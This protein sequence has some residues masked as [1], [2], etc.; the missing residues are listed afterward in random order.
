VAIAAQDSRA[1]A[2]HGS[3]AI[4][5]AGAVAPHAGA[6]TEHVSARYR[7]VVVGVSTAVNA[8]AW[9]VRATFALFFVAML[10]EFDWGRGQTALGYSLS[11]LG[12]VVFAP[13]AGWL[14][15]RWG[16]RTVVTAGGLTLGLA[17]VLTG[18]T[19]SLAQYYL[20]FGLLGAAGLACMLV[21][22]TTVVTRWF[23]RSRGVA[24]G[25]LSAGNSAGA[26]AFYPVNAWLIA[27]LG[28]RGALVACGG[29]VAC[30]TVALALIYRN[31][32]LAGQAGGRDDPASAARRLPRPGQTWT[33][34]RASRN[35]R[36][37]AAFGMT[38]FGVVG[39]Q[40]V[41]THQVAHAVDRGFDQT[42]VVWLFAFGAGCMMAGNLLGGWL[43]DQLGRGWVFTLGSVVAIGGIGCLAAIRGPHDVRLLL[44]YTVSAFGFGMRIPQ[45]STIPAD[46]FSGPHL[47]AILG[48]VQAG[49]G[50]GG[51]IGPFLGGWLFDVTGS[52][53]LAFAAA[54]AAVAASAVAAWIAARPGARGAI[55]SSPTAL[56]G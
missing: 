17:L 32:P 38:G 14:F 31:P 30:A 11:W 47:G 18:R 5:A 37:W 34:R 16:A 24:M 2:A 21:P 33:L 45:L 39:Y 23:V 52:Y 51:A 35:V 20:S 8:L 26:I 19:T 25:I 54:G 46:V 6:M 42:T 43:S 56:E 10:G 29:A 28:W 50:L 12:F 27:R 49:G 1:A 36:L 15:D 55:A 41:M 48:V 13:M 44:V 9:G 22:S 40:I 7:W 53:R 4:E 3:T